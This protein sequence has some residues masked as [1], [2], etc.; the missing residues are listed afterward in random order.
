[1]IPYID[2]KFVEALLSLTADRSAKDSSPDDSLKRLL[3]KRK[4][5][6]T[7]L[8]R[9]VVRLRSIIVVVVTKI[10]LLLLL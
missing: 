7:S 3:K 2:P 8:R 10:F 6:L 5:Y 4:D 1:M 9:G